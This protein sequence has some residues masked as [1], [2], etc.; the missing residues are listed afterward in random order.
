MLRDIEESRNFDS[1]RFM[2]LQYLLLLFIKILNLIEFS[3]TTRWPIPSFLYSFER[4]VSGSLFNIE[5]IAPN[6]SF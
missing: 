4:S 6:D 5:T 3:Q 1:Y 2:K